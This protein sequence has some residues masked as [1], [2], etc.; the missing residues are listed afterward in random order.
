MENLARCTSV[1][2]AAAIGKTFAVMAASISSC[3]DAIGKKYIS[4]LVGSIWDMLRLLHFVVMA[5]LTYA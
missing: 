5:A 4:S 1:Q 3:A 2:A